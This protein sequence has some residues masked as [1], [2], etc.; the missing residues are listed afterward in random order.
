[1]KKVGILVN[2]IGYGGNE[3]SAV[4]VAT[5]ISKE[6][7][8]TIIIQENCGNHYGYGGKIINLNT[9]CAKSKMGKVI[10]SL[11]RIV[12][13]KRIIKEEHLESLF[14]ILPISNPINYLRFGCK[15]IVSCRDC[16]DLI[17]RTNKYISMT[18]KSDLIVCNSEYQADY[19]VKQDSALI[20]KTS[21]IYNI[22]DRFCWLDF[23]QEQNSQLTSIWQKKLVIWHFFQ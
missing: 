1:M 18:K 9:P 13:L 6:Y 19:L 8:V 7:D 20:S 11:K 15:K 4:N 3:R 17:R 16:G 5:A 2:S 22:I 10:N 21:V 12:K 14:I 23:K